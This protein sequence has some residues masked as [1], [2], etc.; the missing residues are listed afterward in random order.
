[1]TFTPVDI[2]HT[3]SGPIG[4]DVKGATWSCVELPGS[5][6]L[7]GTKR[8]VRCDVVVD[9]VE[10][11]NAGFM[12]TGRGGHMISLDKALQTRLGK[13]IGDT[14]EITIVRRVT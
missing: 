13:G 11:P 12:I 14:V 5:A 1:M 10:V 2:D 4:V 3:F 6:D 9:G 8:S 7:F